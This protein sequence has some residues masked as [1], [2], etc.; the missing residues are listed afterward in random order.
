MQVFE[1]NAL[2][3]NGIISVQKKPFKGCSHPH[4]HS[5]FEIEYIINGSGEYIVNGKNY[6]FESGV[7]YF[8]TPADFHT[9]QSPDSEI[10]NIMF[11]AEYAEAKGLLTL[12]NMSSPCFELKDESDRIFIT[13]IL[14]EI[15]S[16]FRK[17]EIDFSLK[18]LS[19]LLDKLAFLCENSA[20]LLSTGIGKA[21]IYLLGNFKNGI[22]L[23]DAAAIAGFTPEYF[24]S[25]FKKELGVTFKQYLNRLQFDYA[26]KLLKFSD[27]NVSEVCYEAGFNDYANFERRFKLR[28][29]STPT[30]YKLQYKNQL[31]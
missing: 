19:C 26:V 25:V 31:S 23:T 18:L 24:S 29:K 7:L 5:F 22:T 10:I 6:P 11:A 21:L 30:Q 15:L 13:T 12:I 14:E 17:K 3:K 1:N 28:F 8:M 9:V 16:S 20:P 27:L 2:I 4:R